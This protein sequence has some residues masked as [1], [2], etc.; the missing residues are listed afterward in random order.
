MGKMIN[1]WES[2]ANTLIPYLQWDELSAGDMYSWQTGR[3]NHASY[4]LHIILSGECSLSLNNTSLL[5]RAG[6]GLLIAPEVFHAPEHI[7][8]PFCRFSVNFHPEEI[9]IQQVLLPNPRSFAIFDADDTLCALCAGILEESQQPENLFHK[10]L[11]SSQLAQLMLRVFRVTSATPQTALP[12]QKQQED[13]TVIDRFFVCTEPKE[14][15]KENLAKLL[16]C[17]QRQALR[18]IHALYGISFQKKQMLSRLDTA[19]HLLSTTDKSIEEICTAV[20]YADAAAFYKA[21]KLYTGTTPHKY[22]KQTI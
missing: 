14:R 22:R 11:L 15:T 1:H 8:Q 13:M 4:E 20:G 17:S 16:H 10:Q 3:H 7:T 21:F 18:K 9:L 6:Q 2:P 5:L 19:Q 12:P